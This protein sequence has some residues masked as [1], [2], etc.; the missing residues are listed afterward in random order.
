M[1]DNE[2]SP[3]LKKALFRTFS[4]ASLLFLSSMS[5][6]AYDR[7]LCVQKMSSGGW[8]FS[9]SFF[10]EVWEQGEPGEQVVE[11]KMEEGLSGLAHIASYSSRG[12]EW[13]RRAAI[14]GFDKF[15]DLPSLREQLETGR[16]RPL[17]V[18]VIDS[19][20][21]WVWQLDGS[22]KLN[23]DG[24]LVVDFPHSS[25]QADALLRYLSSEPVDF[26][27][28][29]YLIG[30]DGNASWRRR[31]ISNSASIVLLYDRHTEVLD[32]LDKSSTIED[33]TLTFD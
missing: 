33:C 12:E 4:A 3:P 10:Y 8:T 16:Y 21:D 25:K 31:S 9:A 18:K 11:Y 20:N 22:G 13:S 14:K 5:A 28:S 26:V 23:S 6:S 24:S 7:D 19:D 1:S 17:R 15:F 29:G 27:L 2:M 32:A 30:P